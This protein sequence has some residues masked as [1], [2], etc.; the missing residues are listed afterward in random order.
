MDT[1]ER[2]AAPETV[3]RWLGQ[4][5][6]CE[7]GF[8]TTEGGTVALHGY[9]RPGDGRGVVGRCP[10]EGGL[11]YELS[12][13]LIKNRLPGAEEHL[14]AA[15][16]RLAEL[17]SGTVTYFER[18]HWTHRGTRLE[19]ECFAI[20]VTQEYNW[21]WAMAGLKDEVSADIRRM[22]EQ[23]DR[24]KK[25]IAEWTLRPLTEVDEEGRTQATRDAAAARAQERA[26]KRAEK[27]AK[28]KV[29]ADKRAA[30]EEAK[31]AFLAPI[32]E[33]LVALASTPSREAKR[34][35]EDI[36]WDMQSA[37]NR[38]IIGR[39]VWDWQDV[40]GADAALVA[41]GF[42]TLK[43]NGRPIIQWRR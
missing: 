38:S 12:C 33:K 2:N 22:A 11:A 4:C 43:H 40:L 9:K 34:E 35:A 36:L 10:G 28:A 13:N 39:G 16:A 20:G 23:V 25:R 14:A 32:R 24:Y 7:G 3:T 5:Q 1:T 21:N 42:E 18:H 27:E 6:L 30:K 15:K 26:D 41:L 19:R 17:E 37:K 31:R 8:K 29:L